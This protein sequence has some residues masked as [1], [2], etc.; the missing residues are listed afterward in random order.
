MTDADVQDVIEY[1]TDHRRSQLLARRHRGAKTISLLT[2]AIPARAL[3]KH[4]E[5]KIS[6]AQVQLVY[7][8]QKFE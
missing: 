8:T 7:L 4:T 1:Y 2:A 6:L 3:L 5:K